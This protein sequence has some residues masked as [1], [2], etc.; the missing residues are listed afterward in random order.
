LG[1]VC[2]ADARCLTQDSIGL[3]VDSI[4]CVDWAGR[5]RAVA[6]NN[7]LGLSSSLGGNDGFSDQDGTPDEQEDSVGSEL[8]V[9]AWL[10]ED[11]NSEESEKPEHQQ[12]EEGV[13]LQ[14]SSIFKFL[15]RMH[16]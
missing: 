16:V 3:S 15:C 4:N 9:R 8:P 7:I 2:V 10:S 11:E 12:N 6:I 14:F 1:L 5:I 13:Q